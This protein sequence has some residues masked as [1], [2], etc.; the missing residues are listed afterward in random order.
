MKVT[1]KSELIGVCQIANF[2]H[3]SQMLNLHMA[4]KTQGN[5]STKKKSV[6]YIPSNTVIPLGKV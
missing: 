3:L 6:L 5:F 1:L 2:S 4:Y